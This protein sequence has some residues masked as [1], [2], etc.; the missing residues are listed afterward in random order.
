MGKT[1]VC[2]FT[3]LLASII[4]ADEDF[5]GKRRKCLEENNLSFDEIKKMKNSTQRSEEFLCTIKCFMTNDGVINENG[6]IDVEKAMEDRLVAKLPEDSQNLLMECLKQ[7][8]KIETCQDTQKVRECVAKV[9]TG[10]ME[11]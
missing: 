6:K 7:I 1:S 3:L 5:I 4:S 11:F 9:T 2:V 10:E 8:D